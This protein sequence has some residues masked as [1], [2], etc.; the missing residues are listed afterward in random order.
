M[1]SMTRG[2]AGADRTQIAANQVPECLLADLCFETG[3]SVSKV[4]GTPSK[5]RGHTPFLSGG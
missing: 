1:A 2:Q 4:K 5:L 3:D